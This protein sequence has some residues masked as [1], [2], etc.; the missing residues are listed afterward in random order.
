MDW[1]TSKKKQKSRV[2]VEKLLLHHKLLRP[3]N[4][5]YLGEASTDDWTYDPNLVKNSDGRRSS[6]RSHRSSDRRH[7]SS[8]RSSR[9][10]S[11]RRHRSSRRSSHRSSDRS[12]DRR[13]RS[14]HRSSDRSSHRRHRSSRRS[15][16]AESPE[17]SKGDSLHRTT[18]KINQHKERIKYHK[19]KLRRYTDVESPE[20]SPGAPKARESDEDVFKRY[21][22][23]LKDEE[24]KEKQR[25]VER[26]RQIQLQEEEADRRF[27][28]RA[29]RK[30]EEENARKK[31]AE[32][33]RTQFRAEQ[34]QGL[35]AEQRRI[36]ADSN[37]TKKL[38]SYYKAKIAAENADK[39]KQ[40]RAAY[41]AKIAELKT[42]PEYKPGMF[43]QGRN[44]EAENPFN[45]EKSPIYKP[46]TYAQPMPKR[47]PD[48]P[49]DS[50]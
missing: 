17:I 16:S 38:D 40:K 43:L 46:F 27:D 18:R 25:D 30:I 29:T 36:T 23:K 26:K 20:G 6:D 9:R 24:E 47:S 22:Q 5:Y 39:D 8:H 32:D 4:P 31:A 10:S 21:Q 3:V 50:P 28:E 34:D 42:K 44:A 15:Y 2:K 48:S 41:N 45:K 11:D 33:L 37:Y 19:Q 35:A 12:S 14:S 1:L 49:P 13:H 7:R